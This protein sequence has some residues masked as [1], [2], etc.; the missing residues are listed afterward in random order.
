MVD[1]STD[2]AL[3]SHLITYVTYLANDGIG[4][5]KTEFLNLSSI[6]NGTTSSILE[7][8]KKTRIKYDLDQTHL[9]GHATDRAASIVGV[10][11][12]FA[13][14]L[15]REVLHLFI[16]HCIA[17]REALAS[18][19]A[20]EAIS[21]MA[22]LEKLLNRL[23]GWIGKPFLRNEALQS[24]LTVMEIGRLKVLHVHNVRWLSMGQVMEQMASIMPP[25]LYVLSGLG[26]CGE[27]YYEF[28]CFSVL[29][30]IHL[31]ANVLGELNTLNKIFQKENLDL[32]EIGE[33]IDIT[34][35]SLSRKFLVNED[36]E[37]SANTKFVAHFLDISRGGQIHFQDSR[38]AVH[39]YILHYT[40]LPHVIDFGVDGTLQGC[41]V[42]A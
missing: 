38:G 9:V 3:E 32:T 30:F 23:Y 31:L 10:H 15:K 41:K 17:H 20:V 5:P 14:K 7:A 18:K 19:D 13:T 2:R 22:S 27:L 37:F 4:Q 40:P 21:P 39:S 25:I 1:E 6:P 11:E 33:A 12:G 34:T 36:E 29:F 26:G 42:I 35:R 24:L 28:R 16:T 8:W